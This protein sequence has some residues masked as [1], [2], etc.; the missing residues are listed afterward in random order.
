MP[1]KSN[2]ESST[3]STSNKKSSSQTKYEIA[4]EMGVELGANATARE[5]GMV[6]NV[7]ISNL[8]I[9]TRVYAGGWW[10]KGEPLIICADSSNG[11]IENVTVSDVFAES[12]NGVVIA[13]DNQN[14]RNVTINNF[15]IKLKS[16]EN[17]E[18]FGKALDLRPN[19]YTE[20]FFQEPTE[21]FVRDAEVVF[22]NFKVIE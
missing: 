19:S 13:G 21:K 4:E 12:E 6:S 2:K 11:Q 14:V 22:N 10:G 1:R 9:N 15:S 8:N 20:N 18:L 3:R 17:R 5:N 16:S 7:H